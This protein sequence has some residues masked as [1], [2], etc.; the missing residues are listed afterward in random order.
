MRPRRAELAVL[1][2]LLVPAHSARG[3]AIGQGFDLERAG[4][5][6]RAATVYFTTLRAEP[7]NLAALLGL[8]RVLPSLSRLPDLLPAA[9]RA[10]AASPRNAALRALLLRTYV[11]L[12]EPDSA[13]AVAQRWTAEQ[14]RDEAPYREWAIALEDAHRFDE[15]RQVFLFGRRALGRPGVFGIELGELLERVGEWEEA[16]REWAA[17]LSEAPAQLLSAASSLAE[18]PV[19]QRERI[20]RAIL[21][22]E[23]KPL[24]RRLAGELLLGW[25]QPERAWSVFAP[26]VAEPSSDAATALRRFADL[27]NG[28]NT[29]DARR[30]RAL[31]LARYADMVP[32]PLAVRARAEAARAFLGAGDRV[33]ARRVLAQ[34][35]ADSTAPPDAQALAQSALVEALIDDGQLSEAATRLGAESR[36]SEDD[37]AALR[38]KLARAR[39]Q[40]GELD[41]ADSVLL[42]DS[43]VDALALRGWVALYSGDMKEAQE[44]FRAAG[45]YAGDRR[46]ATERSGVL[47]LLQQLP[48][49]RFPE[50]GS[51]L[52]LLARGDSAR[53][54]QSLRLAAARLETRGSGGE[55]RADILLLAGRAA[56]RRDA[57][58]QQTALTLFAEV[59]GTPGKSAAAPAA[60]LEWA[61]LLLRQLKT[62]EAIAHLE[63]LILAYPESA[64]VPEARRELERAKGAIPKS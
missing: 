21:A 45:P 9:Q 11:A 32:E 19:E 6:Q 18:A 58:Q 38:L 24:E 15:A 54:V 37:R 16:A 23:P 51:A 2:L 55:G 13:R 10:V 22:P 56:V 44:M 12:N 30:V 27:A 8:E 36:L 17:A 42:A 29:P 28:G 63:H 59:A 48:G 60:E 39:I 25:G 5:Y 49:D 7:T 26:A 64:V 61:R 14:P 47:A 31:A 34:V 20:V 35:A 50:L 40:R 62:A 46:D 1:G 41:L 43:S 3:Q 33:A 53:A 4:Q 52:L 57:L